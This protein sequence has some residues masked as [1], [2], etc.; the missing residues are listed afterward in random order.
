MSVAMINNKVLSE[1]DEIEGY[2]VLK[3]EQR[4]VTLIKDGQKKTLRLQ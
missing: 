3:I 1:G 4:Q 2:N